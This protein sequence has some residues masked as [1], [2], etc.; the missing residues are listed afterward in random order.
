MYEQAIFLNV[1][2]LFTVG[3]LCPLLFLAQHSLGVNGN[4]FLYR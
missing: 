4:T 2:I 3:C 1:M